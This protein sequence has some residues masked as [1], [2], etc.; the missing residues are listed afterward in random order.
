MNINIIDNPRSMQIHIEGNIRSVKDNAMIKVAI[1]DVWNT[2][3]DKQIDIF[4]KDSFI[5]TSSV[6]GFLIK[7]INKD[8]MPISLYIS[9]DELYKMMDDMKLIQTLNVR[10]AA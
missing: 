10:K 7:F 8:K 3:S 9:N 4:I 6:I 5:V 1:E 2:N